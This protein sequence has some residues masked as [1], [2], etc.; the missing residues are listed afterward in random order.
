MVAVRPTGVGEGL[1]LA[2]AHRVVELRVAVS[3]AQKLDTRSVDQA[4]SDIK[5]AKQ[6][7]QE[8][9]ADKA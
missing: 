4:M 1:F 2:V 6:T 7:K 5:R 3:L 8:P 9:S